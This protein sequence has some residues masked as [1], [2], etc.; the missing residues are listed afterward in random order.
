MTNNSP[1]LAAAPNFRDVGGYATH[2]GERVRSGVL[3]RA[4]TL[5]RLEESDL[6]ALRSLGLRQVVDLRTETERAR[7][8][9]RI[10]DGAEYVPLDVTP[11]KSPPSAPAGEREPR[12]HGS[13]A[14]GSSG[15]PEAP[16]P[17]ADL[18]TLLADA[19]R[20]HALLAD[21][22]AER[23]MHGVNRMLVASD[24]A[25]SG[26]RELIQR[27]AAGPGALVFHCSAGKDRTGWGAAVLLRLLGV[28]TETVV[29]DYLASNARLGGLEDWAHL[30]V[31]NYGFAPEAFL[32]LVEVRRE[33]LE[34]AFAEADR[35]HGSFDAYVRDGLGI[36]QRT[37]RELR[38]RMLEPRS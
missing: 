20:A 5:H 4:G 23:F 19:E 36:S 31:R 28:P 22:G 30:L 35:L 34:T 29:A 32:P 38:E 18:V 26:Y 27:A 8:A 10:P 3:Y 33:Y 16:S 6:A 13:P 12:S 9:D 25:C 2:N 37:V 1:I 24:E 17:N 14:P 11:T 21:N 7:E 15:T